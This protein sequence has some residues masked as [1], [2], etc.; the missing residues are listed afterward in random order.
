MLAASALAQ[1]ESPDVPVKNP[2]KPKTSAKYDVDRIGQRGVGRGIN[3]YSVDRERTLGQSMAASLDRGAKFVSDQTVTNYVNELGQKIVRNSD[4]DVPFTIKVLDSSDMG[5]FGLPGGFLYVDSGLIT[6]LDGEAELAAVMA[7]EIGHVAARHATRAV[8]R[9]RISQVI[10]TV[11]LFAGPAGLAL[12]DVGGLGGPL[13]GKKF[14]RDAEYEADL[15]GIEYIYAAG[16]DPEAFLSALE[17]LHAHELKMKELYSKIPGYQFATKVPFH[18][19]IA[20]TFSNYPLTEDRIRRLQEEVS[21]FLPDKEEYVSDSSEFHEVKAR[22]L[23]SEA[24]VLRRPRP[25]A[26][27]GKGPVLR[28]RQD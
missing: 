12:Q 9:R 16:Y 4:A 15:L 20:R 11:G 27:P 7:H 25:G 5:A 21:V 2:R 13:S 26:E 14:S 10:S 3:V 6:A 19:Q 23:A 22:L 28:R 24:P 8:T 1:S 17:K 18:K